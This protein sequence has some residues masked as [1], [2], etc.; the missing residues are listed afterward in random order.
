MYDGSCGSGGLWPPAKDKRVRPSDPSDAIQESKRLCTG[1][2]TYGAEL[3]N[4]GTYISESW[5]SQDAILQPTL[6]SI[7]PSAALMPSCD[8]T[9][10]P[11]LG[12]P[13]TSSKAHYEAFGNNKI[14]F[15]SFSND[16]VDPTEEACWHNPTGAAGDLDY[17]GN[18]ANQ[19]RTV[20][21]FSPTI[22][23]DFFGMNSEYHELTFSAVNLSPELGVQIGEETPVVTSN[24]C[25]NLQSLSTNALLSDTSLETS[26]ESS[27]LLEV[28][29]STSPIRQTP[30][31]E[32]S[33]STH[34]KNND[35]VSENEINADSGTTN[36]N[37]CSK[38]VEMVTSCDTCF[39]VVGSLPIL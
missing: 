12:F 25:S 31:E 21:C 32:A 35:C 8:M 29:P 9:S 14:S 37:T 16:P 23:S 3:V 6:P 33:V 11:G 20:D 2:T 4:H 30:I 26:N 36:A 19:D 39:G 22:I 5:P 38:Y 10:T 13:S 7:Q 18:I 24:E 27:S 15:E 1:Q 28:V 34:S 17:T